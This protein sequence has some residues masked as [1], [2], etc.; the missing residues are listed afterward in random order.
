MNQKF[1]KLIEEEI[2]NNKESINKQYIQNLERLKSLFADYKDISNIHDIIGD[3]L[4]I[5]ALLNKSDFTNE[6]KIELIN[7]FLM[8]I[9]IFTSTDS[10]F[11]SEELLNKQEFKYGSKDELLELLDSDFLEYMRVDNKTIPL[12]EL[13]KRK[14]YGLFIEKC[15]KFTKDSNMPF[16]IIKKHYFDKYPLIN[17]SDLNII[18][19]ALKSLNFSDNLIDLFCDYL[20]GETKET[21]DIR[22]SKSLVQYLE[23][24][25]SLIDKELLNGKN[26]SNDYNKYSDHMD[27]AMDIS[28]IISFI[29]NPNK[30]RKSRTIFGDFKFLC[31]T[32]AKVSQS[33]Q[34]NTIFY[35]I[36][37]NIENGILDKE[38]KINNR[39]LNSSFDKISISPNI[40]FFTYEYLINYSKLFLEFNEEKDKLN[41]IPQSLNDEELNVLRNS[42]QEILEHY[43]LKKDSYTEEDIIYVINALRKLS[44]PENLLFRI[45]KYLKKPF[46][47]KE[48][49]KIEKVNIELKPLMSRKVYNKIYNELLEYFDF[50][51]MLPINYLSTDK[52]IYC[53][54]LLH[55]LNFD[56]YTI[57][58]FI[59]EQEK[60]NRK[61]DVNPLIRYLG[62]K[63][64]ME[65][66]KDNEQVS[67]LLNELDLVFSKTFIYDSVDDYTFYKDYLNMELESME[68]FLSSDHEYEYSLARNK[69]E[70]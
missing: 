46:I 64:K 12:V 26:N 35:I 51:S 38:V 2:K 15:F 29:S 42:H 53:I 44:I 16:N 7:N 8:Y 54:Y 22:T 23:S 59:Q 70:K 61:C 24:L 3:G 9:I 17:D 21:E 5:S 19:D 20:K 27:K 43:L 65:Y 60:Y 40:H 47:K 14:E 30:T 37:K 25:R 45:E 18:K 33:I 11:I 56:E 58:K 67:E 68:S 6:E 55:K 62:L 1:I 52:I 66:Y 36:D 50:N 13:E 32:F 31:S 63:E 4:I 48:E 57:Q 49:I 39:Y 41:T 28:D 69:E 34:I 10:F